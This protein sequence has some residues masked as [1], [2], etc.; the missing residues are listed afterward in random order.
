MGEHRR[1]KTLGG[2]KAH[3]FLFCGDVVAAFDFDH[4]SFRRRRKLQACGIFDQF[5]SETF[6]DAVECIIVAIRIMM[7]NG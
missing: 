1:A 3:V 6:D 7:A 4:L 5:R 2:A